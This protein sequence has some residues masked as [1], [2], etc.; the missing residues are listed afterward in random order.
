[1]FLGV[2][3]LQDHNLFFPLQ[4][5]QWDRNDKFLIGEKEKLYAEY[6]PAENAARIL[7]LKS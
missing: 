5:V 2:S 1:M 6:E 3:T 7:A 4:L